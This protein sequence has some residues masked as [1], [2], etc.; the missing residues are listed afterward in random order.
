MVRAQE[1]EQK[2]ENLV[3]NGKVFLCLKVFGREAC[4]QD[5]DYLKINEINGNPHALLS[6]GC[7]ED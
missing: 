3:E 5:F 1:E 6:L 2:R 4:S 7:K